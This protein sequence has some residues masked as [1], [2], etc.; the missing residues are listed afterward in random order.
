MTNLFLNKNKLKP[1]RKYFY[2]LNK[3]K[4]KKLTTRLLLFEKKDR[5]VCRNKY[6]K[7]YL[8]IIYKFIF[9]LKQNDFWIAFFK[10]KKKN[11]ETNKKKKYFL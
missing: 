4:K 8:K 9:N 7:K 3:N 5:D 1:Q 6:K 2:F 11:T 10:I